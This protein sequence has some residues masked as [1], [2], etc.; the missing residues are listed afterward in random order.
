MFA[1]ALLVLQAAGWPPGDD[2]STVLRLLLTRTSKIIRTSQLKLC[3]NQCLT[4]DSKNCSWC[5]VRCYST[6]TAGS[7]P[8][9][10]TS[11]SSCWPAT[12]FHNPASFPRCAL[13]SPKRT[14]DSLALLCLSTSPRWTSKRQSRSIISIF[15]GGIV[16]C[17][18]LCVIDMNGHRWDTDKRRCFLCSEQHV[19]AVGDDAHLQFYPALIAWWGYQQKALQMSRQPLRSAANISSWSG[20]IA[21]FLIVAF[22]QSSKRLHCPPT[23]LRPSFNSPY[24]T[25]RGSRFSGIRNTCPVHLSW[26]SAMMASIGRQWALGTVTDLYVGNFA[27]P[28]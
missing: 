15:G 16:G 27:P 9:S 22:R 23:D 14:V 3:R 8:L 19:H 6:V 18:V 26:R 12:P 7:L 10:F 25:C 4:I 2:R 11:A 21:F 5:T 13:K 17:T 1:W 28:V 24:S 20:G